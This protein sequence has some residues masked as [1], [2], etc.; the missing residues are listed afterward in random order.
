M[1]G[2]LPIHSQEYN[3]VLNPGKCS[4]GVHKHRKSKLTCTVRGVM[5]QIDSLKGNEISHKLLMQHSDTEAN[6]NA[7]K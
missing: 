2:L 3:L 4:K 6:R 5:S 1:F 7:S